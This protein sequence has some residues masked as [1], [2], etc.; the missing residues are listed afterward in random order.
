MADARSGAYFANCPEEV[1]VRTADGALSL[2]LTIARGLNTQYL[3]A[4][5]GNWRDPS[6][7]ALNWRGKTLGIF[8][9]GNIGTQ[10][11][12][13]ASALGFKIIYNNR[14]AVRGSRYEWVSKKDLLK[15]ADIIL[16]LVPLTEATRH[17]IDEKAFA[18]AKDGVIL[19]NVGTHLS[20]QADTGRFSP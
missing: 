18:Q 11:A 1:G 10:V 5:A 9:L 19:V 7:K 12:N 15:R 6:V 16:V 14:S 2:I 4:R 13:S 17:F 20:S 8:G 3:S